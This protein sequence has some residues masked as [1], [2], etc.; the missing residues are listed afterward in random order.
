MKREPEGR[1]DPYDPASPFQKG[2]TPSI[3]KESHLEDPQP[4]PSTR[5]DR[6][7]RIKQ[8]EYEEQEY[9]ECPP[10]KA[11]ARKYDKQPA[12]PPKIA[13]PVDWTYR[14]AEMH[15]DKML[16]EDPDLWIRMQ[17]AEDPQAKEAVALMEKVR[18]KE[19]KVKQ[20]QE[21]SLK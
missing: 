2:K 18:K 6:A 13:S 17:E 11:E 20:L 15:I 21:I 9:M 14:V 12:I 19:V 4:G 16:Q 8:E 7:P 5:Q 10:K 3:K 1:E